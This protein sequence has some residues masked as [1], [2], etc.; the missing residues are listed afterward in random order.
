MADQIWI[1]RAA[2][3]SMLDAYL[4]S[5]DL[6]NLRVHLMKDTGSLPTFDV[7]TLEA[8]LAALEAD[9][10]GYA[11]QLVSVSPVYIDG[12]DKPS[13]N[14]STAVFACSSPAAPAP[15]T[16]IGWYLTDHTADLAIYCK[17]DP[18]NYITI[19]TAGQ[20]LPVTPALRFFDKSIAP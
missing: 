14:F 15:N 1:T 10:P 11:A 9:F 20:T 19:D 3:Q 12:A 13:A 4:A 16:I 5:L 2:A 6:T 17:W 18:A 8:D 7:D